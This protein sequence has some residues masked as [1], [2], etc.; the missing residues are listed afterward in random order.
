MNGIITVLVVVIL[1]LFGINVMKSKKIKNQKEEIKTQDIVIEKKKEEMK[2]INEVQT[3]INEAKAS[4]APGKKEAP[5]AGD[6]SSRLER[7][8]KLHS[9]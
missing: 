9:N 1:G 8:N 4:P 5:A 6:S 2:R 7:L 3:K